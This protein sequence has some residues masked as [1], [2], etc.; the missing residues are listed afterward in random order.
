MKNSSSLGLSRRPRSMAWA[1]LL[2]FLAGLGQAQT[3]RPLIDEN[4]LSAPGKVAKGKIEYFN[5][6]TQSLFVTLE[7]RS[8][9]VSNKG[10][11]SYRPLDKNIHVKF[12]ELSFRVPP[13]QSYYIFYEASADS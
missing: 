9:S 1:V 7:T 2:C 5:D 11:M 4:R 10:E 6:T 13:K 12:S 3:V 8:F